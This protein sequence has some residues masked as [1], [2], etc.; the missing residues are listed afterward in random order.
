MKNTLMQSAVNT[1]PAN[2]L[3]DQKDTLKGRSGVYGFINV[4]IGNYYIGSG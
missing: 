1:F 3:A 2:T 4:T